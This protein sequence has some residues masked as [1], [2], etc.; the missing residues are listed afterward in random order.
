MQVTSTKWGTNILRGES[1]RVTQVFT[2]AAPISYNKAPGVKKEDW[3]PFATLL[4]RAQFEA[5]LLVA[6]AVRKARP[7]FPGS[8]KVFLTP[9]GGGVF[10]N[11]MVWIKRALEDA[12]YRCRF[13][14]LDVV[15]VAYSKPLD[16]HLKDVV[17]KWKKGGSSGV[18]HGKRPHE[19]KPSA[20][21]HQQKR[22]RKV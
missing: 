12:L 7:D 9:L 4:L 20:Q 21:Q 2:A 8:N 5:T 3:A 1:N 10:G 16:G 19:T 14:G 13:L 11:E 18:A 6:A 15:M 22:Q 17:Q